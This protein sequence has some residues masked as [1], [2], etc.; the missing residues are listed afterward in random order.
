MTGGRRSDL[1]VYP[2]NDG[3]D[4]HPSSEGQRRA[5]EAFVPFLN[6]AVRRAGLVE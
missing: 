1:L 4:S 5:A 2:T 6:R 3:L